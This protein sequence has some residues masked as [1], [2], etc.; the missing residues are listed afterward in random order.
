[1]KKHSI[2]SLFMLLAA[3]LIGCAHGALMTS[4]DYSEIAVGSP[5]SAVEKKYGKPIAI[6]SDGDRMIYE[7]IE[8]VQLGLQTVEMRRYFFVVKGGK[9]VNKFTRMNNPPAYDE[10]YEDNYFPDQGG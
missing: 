10:I 6:R 9:I 4:D 7:Y 8:R 1:M 5:I 3:I 2:W